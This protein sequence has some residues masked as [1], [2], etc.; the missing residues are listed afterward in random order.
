MLM[1][2]RG[3]PTATRLAV[4]GLPEGKQEAGTGRQARPG[5]GAAAAP[6]CMRLRDCYTRAGE[7]RCMAPHARTPRVPRCFRVAASCSTP[8]KSLAAVLCPKENFSSLQDVAQPCCAFPIM[9][10]SRGTGDPGWKEGYGGL[11]AAVTGL[12]LVCASGI[13]GRGSVQREKIFVAT[14]VGI[15][16]DIFL[17]GF[18]ATSGAG[19]Q[20][21][22]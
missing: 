17:A 20:L 18:A 8:G 15:L 21:G 14:K 2:T 3:E 13:W 7:R 12:V 11:P 10:V 16:Q 4:L 5:M 9:D 6:G 1:A 19:G 22:K